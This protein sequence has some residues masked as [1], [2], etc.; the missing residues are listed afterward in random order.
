MLWFFYPY[1]IRSAFCL[2]NVTISERVK[3]RQINGNFL[4]KVILKKTAEFLN[5]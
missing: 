5:L 1:H 4:H 3:K 2:L